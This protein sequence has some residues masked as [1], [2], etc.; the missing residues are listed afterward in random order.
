M[1]IIC[2]TT[3]A[4]AQ[5]LAILLAADLHPVQDFEIRPIL[6]TTPPITYTM[7][8]VLKHAQRA[9]LRAVVDIAIVG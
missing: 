9:K 8:T 2:A 1:Q 6:S 5:V 7:L 3:A 4:A